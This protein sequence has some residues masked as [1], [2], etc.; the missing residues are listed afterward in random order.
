[1][2]NEH[3]AGSLEPFSPLNVTASRADRVAKL[4]ELQAHTASA[5]PVLS[6][7]N[8]GRILTTADIS[9][10]QRIRSGMPDHKTGA[11]TVRLSDAFDLDSLDTEGDQLHAD[12]DGFAE[13]VYEDGHEDGG[14]VQP[15]VTPSTR[16][17]KADAPVAVK[18]SAS[19]QPASDASAK[20]TAPE[21]PP[22]PPSDHAGS[23]S[24]EQAME[25][26][27]SVN[28]DVLEGDV[29]TAEEEDILNNQ[30]EDADDTLDQEAL[31]AVLDQPPIE[32][33]D[34]TL[35]DGA[36][37]GLPDAEPGTQEH[38]DM[39]GSET[40]SALPSDLADTKPEAV[41][42]A[43]DG[44]VSASLRVEGAVAGAVKA[45]A[46]PASQDVRTVNEDAVLAAD[47]DSDTAGAPVPTQAD[48]KDVLDDDQAK[49]VDP[50]ADSASI[51]APAIDADPDSANPD[52]EPIEPEA[53]VIL[54]TPSTPSVS[55]DVEPEWLDAEIIAPPKV[56]E[57]KTQ[58]SVATPG[59]QATGLNPSSDVAASAREAIASEPASEDAKSSTADSSVDS[60][61]GEDASPI[62]SGLRTENS[63]QRSA[64]AAVSET[65]AASPVTSDGT[66]DGATME[67]A[68]V[69]PP[70]EALRADTVLAQDSEK[71]VGDQQPPAPSEPVVVETKTIS[72]GTK[73]TVGDAPSSQPVATDESSSVDAAAI[74]PSDS[75]QA[76]NS[77]QPSSPP[78]A[79]APVVSD[80]PASQP[81]PPAEAV[82]PT[83]P[84]GAQAAIDAAR[85]ARR[86]PIRNQER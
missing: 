19:V 18:P 77:P 46:K 22:P 83:P 41:N 43:T 59:S 68:A 31:D 21:Q 10:V 38:E 85:R 53:G 54:D 58:P 26:L 67:N 3:E 20:P 70:S 14:V 48:P 63:A 56:D 9:G 76:E 13:P 66:S 5:A 11:P 69:T 30:P 64:D 74:P 45:E 75:L 73:T 4:L 72:V 28:P 65:P 39:L 16:D 81:V 78:E 23:S 57:A 34:D 86:R 40:D 44:D 51:D 82:A 35:I 60:V 52:A 47:D 6:A 37:E 80:Q 24:K 55:A 33:D 8:V 2:L 25:V 79:A 32:S 71:L 27:D 12:P 17:V 61:K 7:E 1:M 84:A 50:F 49:P 36:I 42:A 29:G 62:D 15:V